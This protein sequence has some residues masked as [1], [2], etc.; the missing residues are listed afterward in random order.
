[1]HGQ[2]LR[3]QSTF[4]KR[5]SNIVYECSRKGKSSCSSVFGCIT[6]RKFFNILNTISNA[7]RAAFCADT[8]SNVG[9][10]II[11]FILLNKSGY[12]CANVFDSTLLITLAMATRQ[13]LITHSE[14]LIVSKRPSLLTYSIHQLSYKFRLATLK[15]VLLSTEMKF[16]NHKKWGAEDPRNEY[17]PLEYE[18]FSSPHFPL[19][20]DIPLSKETI[21]LD[22]CSTSTLYISS[23]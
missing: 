17:M 19:S 23:Q 1:M 9:K 2:C 20:V 12:N 18:L 16:N 21:S 22:F 5:R 6:S 7:Y 4:G 10:D 8:Q 11:E 15:R 3:T 13:A 14:D